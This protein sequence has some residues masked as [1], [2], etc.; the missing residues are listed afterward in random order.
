MDSAAFGSRYV[1]GEVIGRG[2]MGRV[3]RATRLG[4]DETGRALPDVA[5]KVLREDLAELPDVVARFVRERDVVRGIQHPN[6]VQ[7][8]DLVVEGDRLGIVMELFEAGH[9]RRTAPPP[10]SPATA[11]TLLAQVAQGLA[12]VH[13]AGVIHRDLKPENVLVRRQDDGSLQLRLTDF[14][15]SRLMGPSTT[16]LTSMIGTPGYLAPEVALGRPATSAADVYALGVMVFEWVTGRPPFQADNTIALIRAHAEDDVPALVGAPAELT[17]LLTA[18]LA[19]DPPARPAAEDVAERLT[20]MAPRLQGLASFAV[21]DS[22]V[23]PRSA[24]GQD[25][26]ATLPGG[27]HARA[28]RPEPAAAAAAAAG[29]DDPSERETVLRLSPQAGP[30]VGP[31]PPP[32]P[33][34]TAGPAPT[35]SEP[36]ARRRPNPVWFAAAAAVLLIASV[37]AYLVGPWPSTEAS[38][39]TARPTPAASGAPGQPQPS[40]SIPAGAQA[41]ALSAEGATAAD[42]AAG[43]AGP[44]GIPAADAAPA[45][46]RATTVPQQPVPGKPVAQPAKVATVVPKPGGAAPVP[47]PPPKVPGAVSSMGLS[48]ATQT[49]LDLAWGGATGATSYRLGWRESGADGRTWTSDDTG[50]G[51][52]RRGV[53]LI[54]LRPGRTYTVTVTPLNSAGAGPTTSRVASTDAAPVPPPPPKVPGA[55]S[56]MG[57]SGATQT[58]LDLAWGGA[59]GATSYRLGW[60]ESGADGRTWTSDDTGYGASR[61]GVTLINLRPGRT[62]TVTVTPLNSAG[63]GPTTSRTAATPG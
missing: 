29:V 60:R 8:H 21:H 22:A 24:V 14:G 41:E 40:G 57:L 43:P 2:G 17:E 10:Q 11:A 48:G 39:T 13:R 44:A 19:K 33:L 38:T 31:P 32:A 12:A 3:Y 42:G 4:S 20:R 36:A 35:W 54:N 9:L 47:P 6:V 1:L 37:T 50:Y 7:V 53:T 28:N 51:A 26:P 59:T 49:T 61:R 63:A 55:V 62:Y 27:H 45:A 58:T 34:S 18:V 15:I 5:V 30:A 56:S 46:P 52:S 23:L 25:V 16:Q